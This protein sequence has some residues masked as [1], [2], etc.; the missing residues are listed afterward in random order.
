M[1]EYTNL[2]YHLIIVERYDSHAAGFHYTVY[3]CKNHLTEKKYLKS[4]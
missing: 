3:L 2:F 4:E 1:K